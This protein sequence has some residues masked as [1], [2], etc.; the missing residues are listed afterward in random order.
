MPT[1]GS[2][3]ALNPTANLNP[4]WKGLNEK[5][6]TSLYYGSM[7]TLP[8]APEMTL[9]YSLTISQYT[10]AVNAIDIKPPIIV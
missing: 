8:T 5:V 2:N 3:G 6:V 1:L 7:V 4:F 9:M 10:K